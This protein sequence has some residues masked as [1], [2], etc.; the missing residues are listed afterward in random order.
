LGDDEERSDEW[1]VVGYIIKGVLLDLQSSDAF[2]VCVR[3]FVR[4]FD[5]RLISFV[6]VLLIVID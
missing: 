2:V 4:C 1:K 3:S 5:F 6:F